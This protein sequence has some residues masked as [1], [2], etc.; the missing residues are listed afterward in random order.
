MA[1]QFFQ[2]EGFI[3]ADGGVVLHAAPLTNCRV[4]ELDPKRCSAFFIKLIAFSLRDVGSSPRAG[5][6]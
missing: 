3:P 4:A 2:D 5:L 6:A 1:G